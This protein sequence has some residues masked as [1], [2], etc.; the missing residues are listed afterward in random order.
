[1][2]CCW[3]ALAAVARLIDPVPLLFLVVLTFWLQH[4]LRH[5]AVSIAPHN[6]S[7]HRR[8]RALCSGGFRLDLAD[9]RDVHQPFDRADEI[10]SSDALSLS[11]ARD[12]DLIYMLVHSLTIRIVLGFRFRIVRIRK[13]TCVNGGIMP[14]PMFDFSDLI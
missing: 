14:D 6:A 4:S 8:P 1:M 5:V 13:M 12:S 7:R 10:S 11:L 2:T 3:N 9:P